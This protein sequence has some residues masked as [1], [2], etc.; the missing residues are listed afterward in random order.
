MADVIINGNVTNGNTISANVDDS[1]NVTSNVS[2]GSQ[3]STNVQEGVIVGSDVSSGAVVTGQVVVGG[4]GP[5]GATGPAGADGVDGTDGVGVAAGGTTG[6]VLAKNSA[7][8]YDTEWIDVVTDQTYDEYIYNSSGAQAG[9]RYNTWSDLMAE[10]SG[11]QEGPTRITFEQDETLPTG[12]WDLDFVTFAGDG[13]ISL[14]GGLIVTIPTGFILGGSGYWRNGRLTA[15]VGINYTAN[16]SLITAPAGVS[17]FSLDFGNAI[18]STTASFFNVPSGATYIITLGLGSLLI[19]GG[20]EPVTVATGAINYLIIGSSNAS[21]GNDIFRGTIDPG[22]GLLLIDSSAANV[23][24]ARTDA[25]LT[26]DYIFYRNPKA[27]NVGFDNS[28]NGFTSTDVQA[29]IEEAASAGSAVSSVFGRTGAVTAATSDYDAN[30]IDNTPAGTIAAT[31][32]QDAINELDAD[33]QKRMEL[34]GTYSFGSDFINFYDGRPSV[35]IDLYTAKSGEVLRVR[36]RGS[37]NFGGGT[38]YGEEDDLLYY[39]NNQWKLI[40][41]FTM[42]VAALTAN[43]LLATGGTSNQLISLNPSS[44]PTVTE[45]SYVKGVTSPIQTQISAKKTDSMA[46]N[47]ILGRGTAGTGAIEEITLGTG[48]SLTGTTLNATGGSTNL[49]FQDYEKTGTYV[50]VGYED[51]VDASWYIYR[52]TIAT[53]VRMYANGASSYATNWTGRAG[54]TYV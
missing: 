53:N 37:K 14:L 47:K 39:D 28:T 45:V 5:Q 9:N 22:A 48:L 13:K 25:N 29:A 12:T 52:R 1:G 24:P 54:L 2:I 30:Q 38:I 46:T 16:V 19:N 27:L 50:Y 35:D 3:L 34:I 20:Y 6:Q 15:G 11:G 10:I 36:A 21:I 8:D 43:S 40:K 33:S 7:T 51:T 4:R 44:Y 31:N 18:S 32:V 41:N 23:D 17:T 26:N 42:T 49:A